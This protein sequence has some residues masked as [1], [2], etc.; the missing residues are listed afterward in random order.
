MLAQIGLLAIIAIAL[1]VLAY[2]RWLNYKRST[3]K[4]EDESSK[5]S[6]ISKRVIRYTTVILLVPT[7]GI[8]AVQGILGSEGTAALFGAIIGYML[9]GF[10][11]SDD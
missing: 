9:R 1:L 10:D 4:N 11:E 7:I 2:T 6:G 3:E 8:L 5:S